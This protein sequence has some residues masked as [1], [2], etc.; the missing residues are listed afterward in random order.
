[1]ATT[2]AE[3]AGEEARSEAAR[4]RLESRRDQANHTREWNK[5]HASDRRDRQTATAT[6]GKGVQQTEEADRER[7]ERSKICT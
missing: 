7:S 3:A 6:A 4:R 5:Q 2:E 1:M